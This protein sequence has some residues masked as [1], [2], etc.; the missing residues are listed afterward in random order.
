MIVMKKPAQSVQANRTFKPKQLKLVPACYAVKSAQDDTGTFTCVLKC[1]AGQ[2]TYDII[3]PGAAKAVVHAFYVARA[4]TADE[5]N[6]E[7]VT[8]KALVSTGSKTRQ[9]QVDVPMLQN[10]VEL[11]A[12]VELLLPPLSKGRDAAPRPSK[13]RSRIMLDHD[14]SSP[15]SKK[16]LAT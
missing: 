5:V 11:E 12:G 2:L 4:D 9:Y 16:Q 6:M 3:K 10:T 7:I 1:V 8:F 14:D 15:K 13:R